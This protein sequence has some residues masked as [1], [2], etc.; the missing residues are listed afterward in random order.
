MK[1]LFAIPFLF[2]CSSLAF[3][4]T[5]QE[6]ASDTVDPHGGKMKITGKAAFGGADYDPTNAVNIKGGAKVDTIQ[7]QAP[8]GENT[9]D[10]A[11]A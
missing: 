5:I 4:L 11:T 1:F 6:H 2:Y 9:N 7:A 8:D 3:G 10:L